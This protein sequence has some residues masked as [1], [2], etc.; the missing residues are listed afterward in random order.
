MVKGFFIVLF[1]CSVF[2]I[3]SYTLQTLCNLH[4]TNLFII[5]F[6]VLEFSLKFYYPLLFP[7]NVARTACCHNVLQSNC[8]FLSFRR[9]PLFRKKGELTKDH[10]S[11]CVLLAMMTTRAICVDSTSLCTGVSLYTVVCCITYSHNRNLYKPI[12]TCVDIVANT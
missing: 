12:S 8:F 9:F 11:T 6:K 2:N 4:I 1:Y 7:W 10:L 3:I 5:S